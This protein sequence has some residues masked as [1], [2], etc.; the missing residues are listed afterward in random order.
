MSVW[1]KAIGLRCLVSTECG[2]EETTGKPL[3]GVVA[4]FDPLLVESDKAGVVTDGG[5]GT[6]LTGDD[7][8]GTETTVAEPETTVMVDEET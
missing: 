3:F 6:E 1:K 5:V 2:V 7:N 4:D 8:D